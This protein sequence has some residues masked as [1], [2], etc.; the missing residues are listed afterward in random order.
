MSNGN[1]DNPA[2]INLS[3]ERKDQ[4]IRSVTSF[5]YEEFDEELSRFR[6]E[7]VV[8]FF[9]RIL[10]PAVYNQAVQDARAFMMEKLEDLDMDFYINE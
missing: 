4:L 7:Q 2:K 6:A 3:D 1:N 5:F 10:G 9:I 8:D